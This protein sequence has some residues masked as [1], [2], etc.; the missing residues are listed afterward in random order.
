MEGVV[1]MWSEFS[2]DLVGY[3]KDFGSYSEQD[4]EES[5]GSTHGHSTV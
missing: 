2:R 5:E 4:G 3:P 1:G